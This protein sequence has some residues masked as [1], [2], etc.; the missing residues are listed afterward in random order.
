MP[1]LIN[2]SF[3]DTGEPRNLLDS[4]LSPNLTELP[5]SRPESEVTPMLMVLARLRAGRM[6]AAVASVVTGS[7]P[8]TY[9]Q[10]PQVD[11]QIEEMYSKIPEYCRA[12][13]QP[14]STVEPGQLLLQRL[15][16]QM[17][18]QRAQIILHWRYLSLAKHDDRYL[19]STKTAVSA[20]LKII[21]LHYIIYEGLKTGGRLYS[22]RWRVSSFFNHDLL[23]ALSILC[24]Y[25]RQNS[26]KISTYEHD[27]VK[28]ALRR[29]RIVWDSRPS[30]ASELQ[31]GFAAIESALPDIFDNDNIEGSDATQVLTPADS[32]DSNALPNNQGIFFI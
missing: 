29:S 25:I 12:T 23:I 6:Y 26:D 8:P 19:Y 24:F 30:M 21:D 3:V 9:A 7:Q 20:A 2:D 31:R 17:S 13:T 11:R 5:P 14:G 10:I 16:I 27:N 4:D 18:H 1:R 15:S 22:M 32:S 28:Q